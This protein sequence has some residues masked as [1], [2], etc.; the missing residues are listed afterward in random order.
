MI[1]PLA[2]IRP[3]DRVR[4]VET[5]ISTRRAAV[6]TRSEAR[7]RGSCG[8]SREVAA[9]RGPGCYEEV[10]VQYLAEPQ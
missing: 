9:G 7:G 2:P 8:E 1:D 5:P 3:Q 4:P 10:N 6:C